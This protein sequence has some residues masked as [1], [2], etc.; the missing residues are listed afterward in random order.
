MNS[1]D[2]ILVFFLLVLRKGFKSHLAATSAVVGSTP[3]LVGA[4]CEVGWYERGAAGLLERS[5]K[6][7]E[8][9]KS[10]KGFLGR[11][12]S[13]DEVGSGLPLSLAG[14]DATGRYT[15]PMVWKGIQTAV[16]VDVNTNR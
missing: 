3:S 9:D 1:H 8:A 13:D 15:S 10:S 11:R 5:S 6:P 12:R 7:K 2:T 14:P 16:I 4:C